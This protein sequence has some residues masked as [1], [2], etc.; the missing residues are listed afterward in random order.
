L[1][2]RNEKLAQDLDSAL[3]KILKEE[4]RKKREKSEHE[5]SIRLQEREM[6]LLSTTFYNYGRKLHRYA[7]D[8]RRQEQYDNYSM[9][10]LEGYRENL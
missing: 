6:K 5:K 10:L 9:T 1:E 2:R 8:A 4:E 3:K 7:D